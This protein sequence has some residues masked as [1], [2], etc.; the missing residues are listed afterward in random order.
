MKYWLSEKS[1]VFPHM[2]KCFPDK[3]MQYDLKNVSIQCFSKIPEVG[4]A[5]PEKELEKQ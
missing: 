3:T 4:G 2:D 1:A 5:E